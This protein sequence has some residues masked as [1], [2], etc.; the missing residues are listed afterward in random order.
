V[1]DL[2]GSVRRRPCGATGTSAAADPCDHLAM[3]SLL[4]RLWLGKAGRPAALI[5]AV[6]GRE[7][8]GGWSVFFVSEGLEPRE[9]RAW[10]LTEVIDGAVAAVA[11]LYAKHPPVDGAELLLAIYPWE[12]RRGPMLD[13]AGQQGSFSARDLHG[14]LVVRGATLEELVTALERAPGVPPNDS[15]FRWI[16]PIASLPIP[17]A[18]PLS[19]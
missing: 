19:E 15:M 12:Y 8:E 7:K 17:P 5:T 3:R 18:S 10:T 13:I 6:A 1:F 9:V 11:S 14:G 4:R 16:R 2:D